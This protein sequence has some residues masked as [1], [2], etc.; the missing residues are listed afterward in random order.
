MLSAVGGSACQQQNRRCFGGI[1]R[2]WVSEEVYEVPKPDEYPTLESTH[3]IEAHHERRNER[4]PH[5]DNEEDVKGCNEKVRCDFLLLI[6]KAVGRLFCS[7]NFLI[8]AIDCCY[9]PS[10]LNGV[11]V[12]SI[13]KYAEIPKQYAEIPKQKHTKQKHALLQKHDAVGN[14]SVF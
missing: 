6:P 9:V 10:K 3:L 13:G 2:N 1:S 4:V 5:K 7:H 14:L 8:G 11:E 12:A